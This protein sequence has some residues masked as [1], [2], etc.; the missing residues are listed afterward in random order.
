MFKRFYSYVYPFLTAISVIVLFVLVR[1]AYNPDFESDARNFQ[2]RFDELQKRQ[3]SELSRAIEKYRNDGLDQMWSGKQPDDDLLIHVYRND[4]LKYWSTNELPV[5][6]FADI[7]FPSEGLNHLQNGWYYTK[8][9]KMDDLIFSSSFLIK[10]EYSY[11]NQ[12]LSNKFSDNF[13]RLAH[14]DMGIDKCVGVQIVNEQNEY[15]FSL[16]P[17]NAPNIDAKSSAAIL[18]ILIITLFFLLL[19]LE[20]LMRKKT[21]LQLAVP[22]LLL[23]IRF[24]TIYANS[25]EVFTDDFSFS[26]TLYSGNPF[27][28]NVADYLIN[29]ILIAFFF[30]WTLLLLRSNKVGKNGQL[31]QFTLLASLFPLWWLISFL[32][33]D[34]VDNSQIPLSLN[35]IFAIDIHSLLVLLSWGLMFYYYYQLARELILR[36]VALKTRPAMLILSIFGLG[37]IFFYLAVQFSNAFFLEAIFPLLFFLS[38]YLT[39]YRSNVRRE[40]G[41]GLLHLFIVSAIVSAFLGAH[42][43]DKER[44]ERKLYADQLALDRDIEA[45]WMYAQTVQKLR[46]DRVLSKI[47]SGDVNMSKGDFQENM[48]RRFFRDF[49]ERYE[50]NFDLVGPSGNSIFTGSNG[51]EQLRSLDEVIGSSGKVSELD[52]SMYYL[53]NYSTIYNYV[54]RLPLGPDDSSAVLFGTFRSKKIPEEIGFPRLLI[55]NDAN[56]LEPLE[57]YSIAKYNNG[58]LIS[59]HGTYSYPS[60]SKVLT[61]EKEGMRFFEYEG[62]EHY[63]LRRNAWDEIVL[64]IKVVSAY[65][66]LTA[67]S[68]LFSFYG[69]LLLPLMFRVRKKGVVQAMGLAMR[70]QMVLIFIV[71]IALLGFGFG[72]GIFIRS[73]YNLYT[74]DVI[75]DKLSSVEI[76]VKNKIGEFDHLSTAENREYLQLIL[77]K[78]AKVFFTDVNLYDKDGYLLATSKQK[79]FNM[80]L[81]SEQIN[82]L[83]FVNLSSGAKSKY[84]HQES[85]GNLEYASAYRPFYNNNGVHLA[86]INLQHFGQQSELEIQIEG[87]LVS[88]INIFILLLALTVLLAL[89]V[90]NWL[91]I[92]LI[93][94]QESLT[95]IRFGKHNEPIRYERNDEIGNLVKAYNQKLEELAFTADQL[96]KSERESAWREMAKQVAHEIKNPLTPM[97]LSIQQLLRTYD[98]SDPNSGAKLE[99]VAKSIIEQI[100]TLTNIANE[101]SNFAKLPQLNK[102]DVDMEEL[103]KNVIAIFESE[104]SCHFEF[105]GE[106]KAPL[107]KGD[108]EQLMRVLNNLIKNA[109]QSIP[110]GKKGQIE[111]G[112]SANNEWLTVRVKDNGVGISKEERSKL[113]V[114]YFT[115]KSTGTG[116]GLAMVKQI[117][118]NHGGNVFV[119]SEKGKGSVF[120]F[121]IPIGK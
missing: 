31:L 63:Y 39:H 7:H 77:Q 106:Q 81:V 40:L 114:P 109:V 75:S 62:H 52:S 58:K 74:N 117:I 112:L 38:I 66:Q 71:F 20:S 70:I 26:P 28:G 87:F 59:Q 41:V 37:I 82:P 69:F 64:S 105:T 65:D 43:V 11:E 67:F 76:E 98:P 61:A 14:A 97:K 92:P 101:F 84:V 44:E 27:F 46:K 24:V 103:C 13:G 111:V 120:S 91:T 104:Y 118:E 8:I 21:W 35:E 80:G 86:Y 1:N 110:E 99:R 17:L 45:E 107:I 6:R 115:T 102:S 30:K 54:I 29:V 119:D 55:S 12:D 68:Y 116:L 2:Q 56:I 73:Q 10:T 83:A 53:T 78:F 34:L 3:D 96:A 50:M 60:S 121:E 25:W 19:S 23:L 15:A 90:S 49:W 33:G 47:A 57:N 16:V 42:N 108:R 48:E 94:L 79:L 72:S 51:G 95:T 4:S 36:L 32:I 5:L 85:I 89:V 113:F 18:I 9:K 88:I 93:T 100:D 22:L